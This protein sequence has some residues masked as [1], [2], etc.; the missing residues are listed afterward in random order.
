M[1]DCDSL[2]YWQYHTVRAPSQNSIVTPPLFENQTLYKYIKRS[3]EPRHRDAYATN[4]ERKARD[5]WMSRLQTKNLEEELPTQDPKWRLNDLLENLSKQ[6]INKVLTE[7]EKSRN[8]LYV[9]KSSNSR[10]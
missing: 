3:Q 2:R 5:M 4:T 7:L 6:K 9:S 10:S 1:T 8:A